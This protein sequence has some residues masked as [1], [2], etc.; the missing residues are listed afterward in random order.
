MTIALAVS[1]IPEGLPVAITIALA[2][3][4]AR[5]AR[6]HVIVRRLPAVEGLG[7]CTLIASDKTGTLTEGRPRI[8]EI[9]PVG[10]NREE[11]LLATAVAVER[12]SDHPLAEAIARDGGARLGKTAIPAATDLKSLTGKGVTATLEGE[13]V[14]I[15]KPEMFGV[16]GVAPLSDEAGSVVAQL[17]FEG[18][19]L[20]VVRRGAATSASLACWIRLAPPRSRR[21]PPCG[22]WA[23]S[24]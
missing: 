13:T 7:S 15:G 21:S 1:A 12:L 8:T 22:P 5:M 18:R 14:W 2:V 9:V 11:D 3:A 4:S 23:S 24:A 19:T 17:R 16:D 20:M 6:R 10:G